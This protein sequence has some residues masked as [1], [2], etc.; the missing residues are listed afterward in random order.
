MP[1]GKEAIETPFKNTLAESV[2]GRK[3][4]S[5]GIYDKNKTPILSKPHSTGA[6]TIPL[7]FYEGGKALEPNAEKFETPFNNTLYTAGSKKLG[8]PPS[9]MSKK[10]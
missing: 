1:K 5:G 6:S 4:T 3:G 2:P 10:K 9:Y 8:Q 7:K